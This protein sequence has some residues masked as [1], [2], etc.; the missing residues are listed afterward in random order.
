MPCLTCDGTGT[1]TAERAMRMN[2][3][4]Q[5]RRDRVQRGVSR[6]EE[7]RRLGITPIELSHREQGR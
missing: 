1:V 4:E 5:M 6:N 7:A 2:A 3:G